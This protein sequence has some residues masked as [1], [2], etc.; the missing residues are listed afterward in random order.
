MEGRYYL[1]IVFAIL[2]PLAIQLSLP[3]RFSLLLLLL[4]LSFGFLT[5]FVAFLYQSRDSSERDR[6]TSS[7]PGPRAS[8]SARA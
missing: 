8:S 1:T 4:L 7:V 5:L 3:L 6:F 2:P